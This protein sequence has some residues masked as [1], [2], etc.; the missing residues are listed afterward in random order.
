[1]K[2]FNLGI[3]IAIIVG[4]ILACGYM[5]GSSAHRIDRVLLLE[6]G[7]ISPPVFVGKHDIVIVTR[8]HSVEQP[9]HSHYFQPESD[10]WLQRLGK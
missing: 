8:N 2:R 7:E 10:M 4:I 5:W 3:G 9:V 6:E 1:M